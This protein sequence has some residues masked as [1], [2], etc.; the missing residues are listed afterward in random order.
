MNCLKMLKRGLRLRVFR[1]GL[2]RLP[3]LLQ[4]I[5]L[6]DQIINLNIL[7]V[8]A[9]AASEAQGGKDNG[10]RKCNIVFHKRHFR[11]AETFGNDYIALLEI[12]FWAN[13]SSV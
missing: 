1:E 9:L 7:L 6:L 10:T 3:V 2:L 8:R 4:G 11:R 13:R 12:P 5:S